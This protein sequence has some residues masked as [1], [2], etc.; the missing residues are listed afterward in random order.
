VC[1]Q[2]WA[3]EARKRAAEAAEGKRLR[4][5]ERQAVREARK[6]ARRPPP[7][8]R[9]L[10]FAALLGGAC[11]SLQVPT[12]LRGAVRQRRA[13]AR[14]EV[15][16][17]APQVSMDD[18]REQQA[19]ALAAVSDAVQAGLAGRKRDAAGGADPGAAPPKRARGALP[20]DDAA[21]SSGSDSEGSADGADA[22]TGAA[23]F[24]PQ[25]PAPSGLSDSCVAVI[26]AA[27][28]GGGGS[29]SS[30]GSE[31]QALPAVARP[32]ALAPAPLAL[33]HQASTPAAPGGAPAPAAA[34]PPALAARDESASAADSGP[35]PAASAAPAGERARSPGATPYPPVDLEAYAGP[36]AL[37]ALGADGLKAELARRGL[38]AGGTLAERA[39]RL[40]L[41]RH[42]PRERLPRK[43]LSKPAPASA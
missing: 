16:A 32:D 41:L 30:S 27:G 43:L 14:A 39:G 8:A 17:P 35:P 31:Q 19:A 10:F 29:S 21:L 38:K 37:Q 12:W 4:E 7:A 3:A 2:D 13:P 40:W 22:L 5:L 1:G 33:E 36:D 15:R 6:Q 18:V 28:G 9:L 11:V 26:A 42:T 24:Q 25:R 34:A 20:L 23:A